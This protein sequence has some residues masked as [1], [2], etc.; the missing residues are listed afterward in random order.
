VQ[1]E[2]ASTFTS[3]AWT[4]GPSCHGEWDQVNAYG[5]EIKWQ[6]TDY[7]G[8]FPPQTASVQTIAKTTFACPT[9]KS[10]NDN[11]SGESLSISD[12]ISIGVGLGVGV[13]SL[14]L[15]IWFGWYTRKSYLIK[16][17]KEKEASKGVAACG[18]EWEGLRSKAADIAASTDSPLVEAIP[19]H[20]SSVIASP[21]VDPAVLHK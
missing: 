14:L 4:P 13:P 10:N 11:N 8:T 16:K 6:S 17:K 9:T 7:Y 1:K 12:K 15:T 20:S 3:S 5:V 21:G 19:A 18:A 2:A